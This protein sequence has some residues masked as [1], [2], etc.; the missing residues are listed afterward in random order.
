MPIQDL[1]SARHDALERWWDRLVV[2]LELADL[3]D[4]AT[5][6]RLDAAA[7]KANNEGVHAAA[8]WRYAR[9]LPML[10]AAVEVWARLGHV[11]G[12]ITARHLRGSVQRKIGD[13]AAAED[14]HRAALHLAV[15][16]GW[17]AGEIAARGGLAAVSIEQGELGRAQA[18]LQEAQTLAQDTL[19]AGGQAQTQRYVGRLAEA[20]KEWDAARRSYGAALELWQRLAAPVEGI[21]T[22]AD[23]ARV[24]LASGHTLEAYDLGEQVLEHLSQHGPARLDEPLRV[25]WTLYRVLHVMQQ[26]E[27]AREVLAVAYGEMQRQ[28]DELTGE[29]QDRFFHAVAVNRAIRAAWESE[30]PDQVGPDRATRNPT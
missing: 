15:E 25:Y 7:A 17:S 19:N 16:H 12:E 6:A 1:D 4:P 24:T 5:R 3:T 18:L 23:L 30:N 28:A 11:P 10:T 26:P 21:E 13:Y 14:D 29:Q 22:I 20:R 27:N 8:A 2:S 9:A